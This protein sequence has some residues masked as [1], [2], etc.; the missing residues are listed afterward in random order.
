MTTTFDKITY[1]AGV[2]AFV[3]GAFRLNEGFGWMVL[4]ALFVAVSLSPAVK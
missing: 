4:G 3:F 1:Y 2:V